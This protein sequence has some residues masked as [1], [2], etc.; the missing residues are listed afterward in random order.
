MTSERPESRR[1]L[2]EL[3]RLLLAA[4]ESGSGK[5]ALTCGILAL[6]KRRGISCVSY[7]CGPDYID[8]MFHRHVLGIPGYNLDSFFLS[9]KQ[10]QSLLAQTARKADIAVI[11]GV[12]GYYDGVAG[13]TPQASAYEIAQITDTPVVLVVD[14]KKSSLSIAALVKGFVEYKKDSRIKGV[15]LNR[16]SP[17]LAERLRPCLEELGIRLYGAVPVCMEAQWESRHLG[18]T[19]PAE[20]AQLREKVESFADRLASCL[21]LDGLLELAGSAPPVEKVRGESGRSVERSRGESGLVERACEMVQV[22]GSSG[23]AFMDGEMRRNGTRV[24]GQGR[25]AEIGPQEERARDGDRPGERGRA[26]GPDHKVLRRIAV[27]RDEAFCFYY[28]ADLEALEQ[29][30]WEMFPFS[31]L[32]DDHLPCPGLTGIFLGGGYP[33]VY[34]KGLSEN[35]AMLEQIR[36]ARAQGIKILAECGGFLYLHETLEGTDGHFYPM[37]GLIKAKGYR[38]DKLFRFGYITLYDQDGREVARGH[39]F[40]YWDSTLPGADLKAVKPHSSRSWDCM[41][42]TDGMIAGFPHLYHGPGFG[43]IGAFWEGTGGGL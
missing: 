13:T 37:A 23:Q 34:A 35:R 41:H 7:K 14:G 33:E 40:H 32:H 12:M 19:L 31:P 21:D 25:R 24:S 2:R 42:V 3:P 11:E 28:Q 1:K 9:P 10:V 22:D 15:I 30:G 39:E 26:A 27:A 20:Q 29:A 16:T 4:P 6:L 17:M 38:T 43:W 8:P 18:L 5:T 36:L